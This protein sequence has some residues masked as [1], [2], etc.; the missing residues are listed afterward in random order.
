MKFLLVGGCGYIG[1]AFWHHL[2]KEGHQI[3]IW[4]SNNPGILPN[5]HHFDLSSPSFPS[6]SSY[7]IIVNFGALVRLDECQANPFNAIKTN[8]A[9]VAALLE[10]AR[11]NGCKKFVQIST[12]AIYENNIGTCHEN[13]NV[14]PHLI[15][16]LSKLFSEQLCASYKKCYGLNT[17]CVRVFNTFG[18]KSS[19]RRNHKALHAHI[20]QELLADRQPI[21]H[22]EKAARDYIYIE[23]LCSLLYLICTSNTDNYPV[24]NACS[25]LKIPVYMIYDM[26][27]KSIQRYRTCNIEPLYQAPEKFWTAYSEIFEGE[28]PF[29]ENLLKKEVNKDVIGSSALAYN[30]LGWSPKFSMQTA[31][32]KTID[33]ICGF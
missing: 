31:I 17:A 9:G 21:L 20:I 3:E 8:T 19:L 6:K 32:D 12:S 15:Y 14:D 27:K 11:K 1:E 7:D 33:E 26:I 30:L 22:S 24:I 25:E 29:N 28:H 2:I 10:Y 5:V 23:D 4:D 18:G 13:R 16:P